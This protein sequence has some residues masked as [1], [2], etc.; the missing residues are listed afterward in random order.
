MLFYTGLHQPSDA[1]RV[2]RGMISALRLRTRRMRLKCPQDWPWMLDSGA[3]SILAT[4]G[5]Y[6]HPEAVYASLIGR[7]RHIGNLQ[8]AVSQ[9]YMCEAPMLAR[10]GLTIRDHQRLTIQRYDNLMACVQLMR[11][12]YLMPV[13]QGY[14]P[15]DYVHH[16]GDY[17][18]RIAPG[19][20]IGVG[21]LCKRNGSAAQI[22]D[23]LLAIKSTRPDLK[24]HGFGIK[25]QSL[26]S[27]L[28]EDLL[29][30]AD[31]M[32]WSFAARYEGRRT[33]DWREAVRFARRIET[34]PRQTSL[35]APIASPST[36]DTTPP[37]AIR[38]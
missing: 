15:E 17:G 16:L 28:V 5:A 8:A 1:G 37:A 26:A 20:W 25:T 11:G 22:E 33:N 9:D 10:T 3:F 34:M 14:S 36:P 23:V 2:E 12:A 19:A 32:A 6:P 29:H 30:S 24:L 21:S 4:H 18:E 27:A 31:S 7:W 38:P 35:L 13:L